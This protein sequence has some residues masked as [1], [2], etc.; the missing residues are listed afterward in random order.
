MATS[1]LHYPFH[2]RNELYHTNG[3]DDG[4]SDFVI[5]YSEKTFVSNCLFVMIGNFIR[6]T[7]HGEKCQPRFFFRW[8]REVIPH[9]HFAV[10]DGNG[11][12]EDFTFL[13][14]RQPKCTMLFRGRRRRIRL[15]E[16]DPLLSGFIHPAT[17]D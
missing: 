17:A 12:Y 3:N 7:I 16:G 8:K 4:K 10:I 6:H 5:E 11:V 14:E 1:F 2:P 13:H 15:R 9:F